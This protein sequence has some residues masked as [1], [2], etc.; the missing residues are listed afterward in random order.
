M[1][2]PLK[3]VVLKNACGAT[4]LGYAIMTPENLQAKS[5]RQA[6]HKLLWQ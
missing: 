2:S 4:L 3:D 5:Q 6:F 1:F